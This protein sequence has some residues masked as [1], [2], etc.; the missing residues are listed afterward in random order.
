VT[1]TAAS[2]CFMPEFFTQLCSWAL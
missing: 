2:V 1:Y